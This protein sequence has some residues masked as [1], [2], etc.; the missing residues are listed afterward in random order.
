MPASPRRQS[1]RLSSKAGRIADILKIRKRMS[2]KC[3]VPAR[4]RSRGSRRMPRLTNAFS[5]DIR[6][7]DE[8]A[9]G[10]IGYGQHA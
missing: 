1:A 5:G 3:R 9:L 8:S 4:Y 7:R 10:S 6:W 2:E